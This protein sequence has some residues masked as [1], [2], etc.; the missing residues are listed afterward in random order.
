MRKQIPMKTLYNTLLFSTLFFCSASSL[1]GQS[2]AQIFDGNTDITWLGL[3]FSQ[4]LYIGTASQMGEAG[5]VTSADIKNKYVP[6]WNKLFIDEMEKYNVAGAVHRRQV[7]YALDVTMAANKKL[8][9]DFFG[10]NPNDYTKVK[11]AD[12]VQLVSNYDFNG[13]SGIGMMMFV[14]GM[15]KAKE[16]ACAYLCFVDMERKEVL[17]TKFITGH[18]GGFGFRNFWARTF[19]EM[20]KSVKDN[21]NMWAKQ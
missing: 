1:M 18:A 7:N 12:I 11:E 21:Y 8:D 9:K 17:L 6:A 14:C 13:N 16:E 15:S 4:M 20:L 3:D 19:Y 2:K 5:E 10:Y